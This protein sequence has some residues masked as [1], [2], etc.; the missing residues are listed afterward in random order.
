MI[1]STSISV[2]GSLLVLVVALSL[3]FSQESLRRRLRARTARLHPIIIGSL[4]LAVAT[5]VLLIVRHPAVIY[6]SVPTML[7]GLLYFFIASKKV[8]PYSRSAIGFALLSLIAPATMLANNQE[9]TREPLLVWVGVACYATS[10]ILVV[11]IRLDQLHALRR[12]IWFHSLYTIGSI[13]LLVTENISLAL[14]TLSM[15]AVVRFV[16]VLATRSS[17]RLLPLKVVGVL[18]SILTVIALLSATLF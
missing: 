2:E 16:V 11:G 9:V 12:A 3:F 6:I 5:S 18:E 17:Y 14:F 1:F 10:S 7:L 15:I 13:I 4:I 8:S